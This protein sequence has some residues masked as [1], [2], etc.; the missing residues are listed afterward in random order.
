MIKHE[1]PL[2]L[3][4]SAIVHP[5]YGAKYCKGAGSEAVELTIIVLLI[6]FNDF[7]LKYN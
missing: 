3:K 6:L 2:S 7:N 1:S 5:V 4:N